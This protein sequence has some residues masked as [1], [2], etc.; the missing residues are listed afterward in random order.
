VEVAGG[1]RVQCI[2]PG[3]RR[4]AF[5]TPAPKRSEGGEIHD[6]GIEALE[7]AAQGPLAGNAGDSNETG[8][9]H[10]TAE[11]GDVGEFSGTGE[12]ACRESESELEGFEAAF[13]LLEG[14]DRA[15]KEVA[16]AMPLEESS[17]S[18]E[19]GTAGSLLVGEADLD[20]FHPPFR[21]E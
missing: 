12:D 15:G 13:A 2:A 5:Q 8:E 1:I 18:Q 10:V 3:V 14:W 6:R 9:H 21:V 4:Q 16:K 19:A 7:E 11:L 17:E 20:R